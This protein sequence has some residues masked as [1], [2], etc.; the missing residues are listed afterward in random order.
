MMAKTEN[1]SENAGVLLSAYTDFLKNRLEQQLR[2]HMEVALQ[3]AVEAAL[4]DM[5]LAIQTHYQYEED[6]LVVSLMDKSGTIVAKT[7]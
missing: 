3:V 1:I 5:K 2:P 4:K 7:P 6:R